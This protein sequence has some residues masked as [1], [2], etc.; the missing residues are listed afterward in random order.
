[1]DIETV[2]AAGVIVFAGLLW[3]KNQ[4]PGYNAMKVKNDSSVYVEHHKDSLLMDQIKLQNKAFMGD[5]SAKVQLGTM[6]DENNVIAP[7]D[8]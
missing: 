6:Y 3:M 5:D 7:I 2:L 4:K 1:M 8:M